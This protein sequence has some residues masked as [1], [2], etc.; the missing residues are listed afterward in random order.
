MNDQQKRDQLTLAQ[1]LFQLVNLHNP[2]NTANFWELVFR[3]TLAN[4]Y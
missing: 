1:L 2:L 4:R 3:E